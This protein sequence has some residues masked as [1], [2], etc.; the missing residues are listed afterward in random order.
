MSKI[1]ETPEVIAQKRLTE[2]DTAF[3]LH[4]T[5]RYCQIDNQSIREHLTGVGE[6]TGIAFG[7]HKRAMALTKSGIEIVKVQ[8]DEDRV[9]KKVG[10]IERDPKFS[11]EHISGGNAQEILDWIDGY[12]TLAIDQISGQEPYRNSGLLFVAP[13]VTYSLLGSLSQEYAEFALTRAFWPIIFQQK[14]AQMPNWFDLGV[15][16]QDYVR[17]L[18]DAI[19]E[20]EDAYGIYMVSGEGS[21]LSPDQAAA[22]AQMLS[23]IVSLIHEFIDEFSG[24][25]D[26]VMRNLPN[27]TAGID[28]DDREA[29]RRMN[30]PLRLRMKGI[31]ATAARL[32][33]MFLT[34]RDMAR[35]L[36]VRAQA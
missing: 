35:T 9:L 25:D 34:K 23:G 13:S 15:T 5:E 1:A 22:I 4:L 8:F 11:K 19:G 17:G 28:R 31:S 6:D 10:K 32:R 36:A 33:D 14:E 26:H 2:L 7:L 21:A 20:L 30:L 16:V 29:I 24:Y 27:A 12:I 18:V 3:H